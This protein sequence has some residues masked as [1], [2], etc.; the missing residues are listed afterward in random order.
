MASLV[1]EFTVAYRCSKS[2]IQVFNT[3]YRIDY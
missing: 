1:I 2:D 3:Q